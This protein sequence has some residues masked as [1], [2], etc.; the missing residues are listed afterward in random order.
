MYKEKQLGYELDDM[1]FGRRLAIE[2]EIDRDPAMQEGCTL[3]AGI[4]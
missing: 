2:K 4:Y 3:N 1:E